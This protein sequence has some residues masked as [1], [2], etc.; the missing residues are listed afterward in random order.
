M[1]H[2]EFDEKGNLKTFTQSTSKCTG[3]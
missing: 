2:G 1:T 3:S